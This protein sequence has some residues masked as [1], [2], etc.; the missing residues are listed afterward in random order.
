M[1]SQREK[2]ARAIWAVRPDGGKMSR[3][4]PFEDTDV[5][6]RRYSTASLD[7][8][9]VAA[10]DLCFDYA[11]AV[12]KELGW[13]EKV[14]EGTWGYVPSP[15]NPTHI[16]AEITDDDHLT[17]NEIVDD[18]CEQCHGPCLRRPRHNDGMNI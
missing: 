4:F 16:V 7:N 18:Y 12:L 14:K 9:K 17:L 11:D 6:R 3:P 2:L 15:R 8:G 1:M 5:D 10:C 13:A